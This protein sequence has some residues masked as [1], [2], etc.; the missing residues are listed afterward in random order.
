MNAVAASIS[1]ISHEAARVGSGLEESVSALRSFL[2]ASVYQAAIAEDLLAQGV[3]LL[4]EASQ[5]QIDAHQRLLL[6]VRSFM[7]EVTRI[8]AFSLDVKA[9]N[10]S[11][12]DLERRV[13]TTIKLHKQHS[14]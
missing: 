12:D 1:S 10:A 11:L 14:K 3:D 4:T 2:D 6:R 7:S 9:L 13:D 5:Q 8:T